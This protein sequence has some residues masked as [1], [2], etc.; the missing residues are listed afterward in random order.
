MKTAAQY[1]ADWERCESVEQMNVVFSRVIRG[2][3]VLEDKLAEKDFLFSEI[4]QKIAMHRKR[5]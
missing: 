5:K 2:Y 4:A 1:E 3:S